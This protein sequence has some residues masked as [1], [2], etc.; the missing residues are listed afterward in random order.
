MKSNSIFHKIQAFIIKRL[1]RKDRY[2]FID[3][4][5]GR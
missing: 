4:D 3:E 2:M 1:K 5:G